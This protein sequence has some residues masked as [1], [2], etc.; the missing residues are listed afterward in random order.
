MGRQFGFVQI[1]SRAELVVGRHAILEPVGAVGLSDANR[2]NLVVF[3]P[4]V[5]FDSQGHRLG[6]GQGGYD[7]LL[8]DFTGRELAVGFAYEFQLVE[9]VP[10]QSWDRS[11]QYIVTE[12]RTVDCNVGS[13]GN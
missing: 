5:V 9:A 10:V 3:V 1:A 6:R 12:N 2:G 7:R 13:M 8:G 11:M 4:G